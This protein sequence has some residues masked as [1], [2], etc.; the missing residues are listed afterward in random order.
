M[1]AKEIPPLSS[2]C[3][4]ER[5]RVNHALRVASGYLLIAEW[6]KVPVQI[7]FSV[8]LKKKGWIVRNLPITLTKISLSLILNNLIIYSICSPNCHK[9]AYFLTFKS[10]I[11]FL[12]QT[13]SP[14]WHFWWAMGGVRCCQTDSFWQLSTC[15]YVQS[16]RP[17][18]R[19]MPVHKKKVL[20]CSLSY[21]VSLCCDSLCA[22]YNTDFS[23]LQPS[24]FV[25]VSISVR[26]CVLWATPTLSYHSH[27]L[28]ASCSSPKSSWPSSNKPISY[29]QEPSHPSSYIHFDIYTQ[30]CRH[31]NTHTYQWQLFMQVFFSP[32]WIFK[33]EA[34]CATV[35]TVAS[36]AIQALVTY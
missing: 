15:G 7:S 17:I 23:S 33:A 8:F 2:C 34:V 24:G 18:G 9:F 4:T 21:F 12:W 1:R 5:T 10:I 30:T 29:N 19:T 27:Q 31:T 25:S 26:L 16:L 13:E 36:V 11:C 22:L 28:L 32:L 6:E 20:K 35:H 14:D 3:R